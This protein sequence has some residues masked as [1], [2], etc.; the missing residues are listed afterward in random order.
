MITRAAATLPL[1]FILAGTLVG[2]AV[3]S[4][5]AAAAL[6]LAGVLTLAASISRLATALAFAVILAAAGMSTAVVGA[7]ATL[8]LAGVLTL[9]ASISGLAAAL[10]LAVI[11]A[12]TRMAFAFVV[13]S[14]GV[15]EVVGL[16]RLGARHYATYCGQHHLV[17]VS[18]VHHFFQ[19]NWDYQEHP[20]RAAPSMGLPP[21]QSGLSVGRLLSKLSSQVLWDENRQ[22]TQSIP[23][24]L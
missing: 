3:G 8:A 14:Q 1:A 19:V 13:S 12:F 21:Y 11:L 7:T 24:L 16:G 15:V 22:S 6:A 4:L 18:S 23:S 2:T 9:A 17:E 20:T 5:G 10:A